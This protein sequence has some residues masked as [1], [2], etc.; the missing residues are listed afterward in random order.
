MQ[1]QARR[2]H[3]ENAALRSIIHDLGLSDDALQQRLQLAMDANSTLH[4]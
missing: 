3:E 1:K 4:V 2:V